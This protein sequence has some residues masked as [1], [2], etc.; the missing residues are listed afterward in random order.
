MGRV[1]GATPQMTESKAK[2][3]GSGSNPD[4]KDEVYI[5]LFSAA[6]WADESIWRRFLES[7]QCATGLLPRR[8]GQF[9]PLKTAFSSID[10][11]AALLAHEPKVGIRHWILRYGNGIYASVA[12]YP[13]EIENRGFLYN[14]F[15]FTIPLSRFKQTLATSIRKWFLE[16]AGCFRAF[17]G[18]VELFSTIERESQAFQPRWNLSYEFPTFGWLTYFSNRVVSFFGDDKVPALS[19][20][21]E[22]TRDGLLVTMGDTPEEAAERRE[23]KI[24]LERILG[25]NSFVVPVALPKVD[26]STIDTANLDKTDPFYFRPKMPNGERK[27]QFAYVPSFEDLADEFRP[28]SSA[29]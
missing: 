3:T 21:A 23:E 2:R 27:P 26:E 28:R 12:D 1:G 7:T 24:Q 14:H 22:R 20:Y 13:S 29:R 15:L 8:F 25:P 9:E 4:K 18:D 11:T 17:Y 16:L 6:S 19:P 5:H 10:E